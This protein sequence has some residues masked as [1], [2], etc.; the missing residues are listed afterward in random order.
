MRKM[1]RQL[2]YILYAAVCVLYLGGWITRLA[3]TGTAPW[4]MVQPWLGERPEITDWTMGN[5][6]LR[7]SMQAPP[8]QA[9]QYAAALELQPEDGTGVPTVRY[10]SPIPCRLRTQDGK[11][12]H[13]NVHIRLESGKSS[14]TLE[15]YSACVGGQEPRTIMARLAAE[16]A[17]ADWLPRAWAAFLMEHASLSATVD[18]LVEVLWAALFL[19]PCLLVDGALL[20]RWRRAPQGKGC[21]SEWLLLPVLALVPSFLLIWATLPSDPLNIVGLG[22]LF[23]VVAAAYVLLSL[24]LGAAA[25]MVTARKTTNA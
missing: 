20:L 3:E 5:S 1:L 22:F 9:Q 16:P 19:A 6:A 14:C 10:A 21:W 12:L 15:I 23:I 18:T 4:H 8:Q 17:W 7:I 11:F 24:L 13:E 2:F 25:H